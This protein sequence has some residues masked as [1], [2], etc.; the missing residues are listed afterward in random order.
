MQTSDDGLP[1]AEKS[2]HGLLLSKR[3]RI[4][5][6]KMSQDNE[7]PTPDTV[8]K[9]YPECLCRYMDPNI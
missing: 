4:L 9:G 2:E 1:E 8:G 5:L 7:L 3:I 6:C